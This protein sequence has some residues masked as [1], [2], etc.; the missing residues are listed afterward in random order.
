ME[1]EFDGE[2]WSWRG[3][4]PYHFVTVPEDDADAIK[5][6]SGAIT[7]GWGMVPATIRIGETRW[8]TSLW[9]KDGAYVVPLK[10][11]IRKAEEIELGHVVQVAVS[12]DV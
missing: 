5:A 8:T 7:Y 12:I 10:D 2:V 6:V 3:P 9:P 1:L 4:A 11:A